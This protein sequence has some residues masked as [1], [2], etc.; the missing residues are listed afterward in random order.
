MTPDER[1]VLAKQV[2]SISDTIA[3]FPTHTGPCHPSDR[4][5]ACLGRQWIQ[6]MRDDMARADHVRA[7]EAM[8]PNCGGTGVVA[9]LAKINR[10][11]DPHVNR[12]CR[13]CK[14]SGV[15]R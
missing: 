6:Q 1:A 3:Q 5:A 8:C 12:S 13:R 10:T 7:V 4:C 2:E 15:K 9:D 14:G 11:G